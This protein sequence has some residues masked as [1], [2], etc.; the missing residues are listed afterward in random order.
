M[1]LKG[2]LAEHWLRRGELAKARDAGEQFLDSA[3]RHDTH[4]HV[5]G[6]RWLLANV[7]LA[8][9]EPGAAVA[10]LDDAL[11]RLQDHPAPLIT[12]RIYAALCRARSA[13]GETRGAQDARHEAAAI[14][15]RVADSVE[16]E[17]LRAAFLSSSAVREVLGVSP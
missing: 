3:M 16:D 6:A 7:A 2:A 8:E 17:K 9:S 4:T 10:H 5:F 13:L 15:R 11:E 12:W 1:R 14:I